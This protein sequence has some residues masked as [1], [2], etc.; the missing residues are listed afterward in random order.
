MENN[1]N[2]KLIQILD[3]IF[4]NNNLEKDNL[5]RELIKNIT[6]FEEL[7]KLKIILELLV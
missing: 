5:V 3:I 1:N 2:N 6:D 4:E 7:L